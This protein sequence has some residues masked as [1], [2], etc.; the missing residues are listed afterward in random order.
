MKGEEKKIRTNPL[1]YASD[2]IR[3]VFNSPE[4]HE[5]KNG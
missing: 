1:D 3:K 2:I 5:K 4:A